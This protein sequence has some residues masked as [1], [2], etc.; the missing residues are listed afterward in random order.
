M[1]MKKREKI[2]KNI[3]KIIKNCLLKKQNEKQRFYFKQTFNGTSC[4]REGLKNFRQFKHKK[5]FFDFSVL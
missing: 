4:F 3:Q 1:W 5:F 2:N